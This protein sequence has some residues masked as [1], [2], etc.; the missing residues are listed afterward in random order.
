MQCVLLDCRDHTP[1]VARRE[2][3]ERMRGVESSTQSNTELRRTTMERR[4]SQNSIAVQVWGDMV[5]LRSACMPAAVTLEQSRMSREVSAGR[6]LTSMLAAPRPPS[7]PTLVSARPQLTPPPGSAAPA[8][9]PPRRWSSLAAQAASPAHRP[10]TAFH[11][12]FST[13]INSHS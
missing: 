4:Y 6:L 11:A 2:R 13:L 5:V 1:N 3:S 12:T 7:P 10:S 8:C 9:P